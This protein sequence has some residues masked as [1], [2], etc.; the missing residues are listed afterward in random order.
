[1]FIFL[2]LNVF[3]WSEYGILCYTFMYHFIGFEEGFIGKSSV[4]FGGRR[5]TC[6]LY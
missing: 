5:F 4:D 3:I 6:S 2:L 1:M